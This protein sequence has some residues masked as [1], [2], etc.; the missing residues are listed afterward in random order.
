[1]EPKNSKETGRDD[2]E[3]KR[4]GITKKFDMR[5]APYRAAYSKFA[6]II[7]QKMP[8]VAFAIPRLFTRS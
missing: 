7:L 5:F 4:L 6:K 3:E 2:I 8:I 1:M